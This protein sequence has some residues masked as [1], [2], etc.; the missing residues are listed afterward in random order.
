MSEIGSKISNWIW[1][2][3]PDAGI[4]RPNLCRPNLPI[5]ERF[6]HP[7]LDKLERYFGSKDLLFQIR[8]QLFANAKELIRKTRSIKYL[9]LKAQVI[10]SESYLKSHIIRLP[11][12]AKDLMDENSDD[13]EK[14]DYVL[15]SDLVGGWLRQQFATWALVYYR[16]ISPLINI[17]VTVSNDIRGNF[18]VDGPKNYR[19]DPRASFSLISPHSDIKISLKP[20][21]FDKAYCDMG[22]RLIED[23]TARNYST[24]LPLV[25]DH[26]IRIFW[27]IQ[28]WLVHIG[29]H[30]TWL[31]AG[32]DETN[33]SE[34]SYSGWRM[35]PDNAF[36]PLSINNIILM[37]RVTRY[38]NGMQPV[39]G[40][41]ILRYL[42][43]E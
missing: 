11:S 13:N 9:N 36:V 2:N 10:I 32:V 14:R 28:P 42:G 35:L 21:D 43:E 33:D 16:D 31:L 39:R 41:M 37:G 24:M 19:C 29:D 30:E 23:K 17:Q 26:H 22:Q 18:Q 3:T 4:H 12:K 15:D 1:I 25:S 5:G 40:S 27:D 20:Q 34:S 7:V 38:Q 8:D 6:L